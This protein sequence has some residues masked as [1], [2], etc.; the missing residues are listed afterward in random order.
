M[1]GLRIGTSDQF[2]RWFLYFKKVPMT[3]GELGAAIQGYQ[4]NHEFQAYDYIPILEG[5]NFCN[6]LQDLSDTG[7]VVVTHDGEFP[8]WRVTLTEFGKLI[9]ETYEPHWPNATT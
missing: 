7:H 4:E 1:P 3:I 2:L 9:A 5:R 8:S 6:D